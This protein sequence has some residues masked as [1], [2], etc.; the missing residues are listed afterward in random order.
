MARYYDTARGEQ[1]KLNVVA[2]DLVW[3]FSTDASLGLHACMLRES[4]RTVTAV[5]TKPVRTPTPTPAAKPSPEAS[6]PTQHPPPPAAPDQP[7]LNTA[8]T[9]GEQETDAEIDEDLFA[10]LEANLLGHEDDDD[11]DLADES[12]V[13]TMFVHAGIAAGNAVDDALNGADG[14]ALARKARDVAEDDVIA[15]GAHVADAFE[16]A[17]VNEV[18]LG[19]EAVSEDATVE[20]E[21]SLEHIQEVFNEWKLSFE[22]SAEALKSRGDAIRSNTP[23]GANFAK[24]EPSLLAMQRDSVDGGTTADVA[25]V[26]WTDVTARVGRICKLE[27]DGDTTYVVYP[28]QTR[29]KPVTFVEA[30]GSMCPGM[31]VIH[32]TIGVPLKRRSGADRT[33]LHP[34][35][36]RLL[37][38]WRALQVAGAREAMWVLQAA[39]ASQAALSSSMTIGTCHICSRGNDDFASV[40]SKDTTRITKTCCVCLLA[41]HPECA[42]CFAQNM[43]PLIQSVAD[44]RVDT[45]ADIPEHFPTVKDTRRNR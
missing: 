8:S 38:M 20:E 42:A 33:R 44:E 36:V 10:A 24:P 1:R 23:L 13:T 15:D 14:P 11:D 12:G 31:S 2:C 6:A 16:E 32:P 17:C 41:A 7:A 35:M 18:C 5:S 43:A 34:N 26:A 30:D 22:K 21:F 4:E 19:L 9:A 25:V 40:A 27:R 45:R 37:S 3:R 39:P 29:Y 28:I